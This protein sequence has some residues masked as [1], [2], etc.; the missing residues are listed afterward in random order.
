MN[1]VKLDPQKPIVLIGDGGHSKVIADCLQELNCQIIGY[2]S[3]QDALWLLQQGIKRITNKDLLD[4]A[5]ENT[6]MTM[7]FIG[8]MRS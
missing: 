3:D 5:A 2:Y 7:A 8:T 6:Q 4:L 1:T